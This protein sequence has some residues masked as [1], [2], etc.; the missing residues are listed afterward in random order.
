M[1]TALLLS[2][3]NAEWKEAAASVSEDVLVYALLNR[4]LILQLLNRVTVKTGHYILEKKNG[5]DR[6]KKPYKYFF[7]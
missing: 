3:W 4:R 5:I 2:Q 7:C 1:L 6:G